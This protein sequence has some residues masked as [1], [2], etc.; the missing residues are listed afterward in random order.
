MKL[1]YRQSRHR[2]LFLGIW[3][4]RA[5]ALLLGVVGTSDVAAGDS[6]DFTISVLVVDEK[7]AP[8]AGATLRFALETCAS[9]ARR[10]M[11]LAKQRSQSALPALTRCRSKKNFTSSAKARSISARAALFRKS[12]S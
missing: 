2:L 7:N 12:M 8:V 9:I 3:A 11:H 6:R 10:Q 1:S 4:F 5:L